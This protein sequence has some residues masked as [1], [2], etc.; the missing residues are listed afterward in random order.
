MSQR[1]YYFSYLPYLLYYFYLELVLLKITYMSLAGLGWG[2]TPTA[3]EFCAE[4]ETR[5]SPLLA[6]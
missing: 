2:A 4:R 1:Q 5:E 6:N 3:T